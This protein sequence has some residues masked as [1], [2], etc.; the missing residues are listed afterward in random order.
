MEDLG[1]AFYHRWVRVGIAVALLGYVAVTVGDFLIFQGEERGWAFATQGATV[2]ACAV[3]LAFAFRGEVRIGAGITLAAVWL[4]LHS[5]LPTSGLDLSALIALPVLISAG[6]ILLG[7]RTGYGLAALTCVT[8]PLGV[9]ASQWAGLG[10]GMERDDLYLWL[11]VTASMFASAALVQ[12]GLDSFGRVIAT[13]QASEQRLSHLLE[14]A[15]DGIVATDGEGRIVSANPAAELLLGRPMPALVGHPL[16]EILEGACADPHQVG[17]LASLLDGDAQREAAICL[18]G[19]GDEDRPVEV[20]VGPIRWADGTVGRQVTLRDVSEQRRAWETERFLRIQL[21]HAQRLEA[22][23]RLAGG[24]A[25][26]FNNLLTVVGGAA[27]LL[28]LD[29]AGGDKELARE[30]LDA[31]VRGASLTRQLLAFARKE[32]TQPTDLFLPEVIRE[33]EPLLRRFVTE[34]NRLE[35]DV[36]DAAPSVP[37]DRSQVEQVL[38]NLVVNANDALVSPGRVRVGVVG[39]GT[40]VAWGGEHQ[41]TVPD[42]WVELWVEDSGEGMDP[43]VVE[44]AFEPFFTTKPR[45]QGTGLGLATVH[46]IVAQNKGEVFIHS[47]R[48][49]GT[50]VSVRWPIVQESA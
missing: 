40:G 50:R 7:G 10:P 20:V 41:W 12:L 29:D 11:V 2:V 35:V 28:L 26:E 24:V 6:G 23:G 13:A 5:G 4:E 30:I 16:Q 36:S 9:M 33:I 34:R 8:L 15:P 21:E 48:G 46:G 43:E 17:R 22:V 49:A 32:M 47:R 38:V 31:K 27:E 1:V 44:R 3:A 14:N 45:G 25:H 18:R 42:G 19:E 37:A 39:P